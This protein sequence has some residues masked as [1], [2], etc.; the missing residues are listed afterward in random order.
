MVHSSDMADDLKEV[1][2]DASEFLEVLPVDRYSFLYLFEGEKSSG[3]LDHSFS[4]VY[5]MGEY[6]YSDYGDILKSIAAHEFFQWS[7]LSTFAGGN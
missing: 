2:E 4:S 6:L 7:F 3:A 5:V 1:I